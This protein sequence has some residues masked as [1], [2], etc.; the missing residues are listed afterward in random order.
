M[1]DL[2]HSDTTTRTARSA[3]LGRG[4]LHRLGQAMDTLAAWNERRRQ[5][6]ALETLPDHILSDIGVSRAD[7]DNEAAK[8]FWRG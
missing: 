4:L 1:S 3:G 8:P 5:R 7:A 2:S 6:L